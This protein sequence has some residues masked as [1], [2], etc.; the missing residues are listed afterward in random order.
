MEFVGFEGC[1]L[2]QFGEGFYASALLFYGFAL[3][4]QLLDVDLEFADDG[5]EGLLGELAEGGQGLE[6]FERVLGH[7]GLYI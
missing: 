5:G 7:G 2:L 6:V 4:E 1:L 3:V